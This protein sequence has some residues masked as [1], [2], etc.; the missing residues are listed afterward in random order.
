MP[1]IME[2]NVEAVHIF[3]QTRTQVITGFETIIDINILA[4]GMVMDL[5]GVRDRRRC[6]AKV[7]TMFDEYKAALDDKREQERDAVT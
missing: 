2:G 3:S 4:V 1:E 7:R 5:M 6:L